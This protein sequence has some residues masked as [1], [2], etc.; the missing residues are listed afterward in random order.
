MAILDWLTWENTKAFL[1]SQFISA[2]LGALFGAAGGAYAAQKIAEKSRKRRELLQEVRNSNAA[3]E[4]AQAICSTYLN[5]KEQHV[6]GMKESYDAQKAAVHAHHQGLE[7][8]TIP[9]GTQLDVGVDL[10]SLANPPVRADRLE[11]MVLGKLSVS[12]R[13]RVMMA[14][15]AQSIA[16]LADCMAQRNRLIAS[17]KAVPGPVNSAKIAFLFGLPR[18][19]VIDTTFGDAVEAL[20]KQTDDCIFFSRTLASDLTRHGVRARKDFTRRFRGEVPVVTKILWDEPERKGLFPPEKNYS[21]WLTGFRSRP[22]R[23]YGRRAE[24]LSYGL[25]TL[26]RRSTVS[27]GLYWLC[28]MPSS[29]KSTPRAAP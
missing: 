26:F 22:R 9:A 16:Q 18:G 5:L 11:D 28:Y 27:R 19:D 20:Y 1:N 7:E 29:T 24:K 17:Y 10:N 25:R 15:L 21:T 12:A 4:L 3:I 8:G 23:T 2:A 14:M 6:R 13:P